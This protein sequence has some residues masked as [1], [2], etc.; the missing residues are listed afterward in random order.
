MRSA[1]TK[2]G[3]VN[4][5]RQCSSVKPKDEIADALHETAQ[6]QESPMARRSTARAAGDGAEGNVV[7]FTEIDQAGTKAAGDGRVAAPLENPAL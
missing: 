6:H 4:T 2:T 7:P 1:L 5:N 3:S